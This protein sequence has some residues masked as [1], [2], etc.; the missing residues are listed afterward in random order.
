MWLPYFHKKVSF[1]QVALKHMG[2]MGIFATNSLT[3]LLGIQL[4]NLL[5]FIGFITHYIAI[6]FVENNFI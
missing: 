6:V 1:D 2:K 4:L 5:I 3:K